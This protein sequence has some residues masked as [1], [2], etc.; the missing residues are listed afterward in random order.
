MSRIL[1]RRPPRRPGPEMPNGELTLQEPP[2]LPEKQATTSTVF[3]YLPMALASTATILIFV[4]PNAGTATGGSSIPGT[5]LA[6]GLMMVSS[7]A[8]L[9]G[10]LVRASGDRKRRVHGARRDYLRYLSQTRRRIREVVVDQR[11]AQSWRNP[12][13]DVLWSLA[14][15]SRLWER[16]TTHDDFGEVRIGVGEQRL[17]LRLAPLQT[18]PVEDLEPLCSHAL[19]RFIRAYGTVADQPVAV[20]L[21]GYSLVGLR[22]DVEAARAMVRAILGQLAVFHSPEE[23]RIGLC[24]SD[25]NRAK[26]EWLKWL[27]HALHRTEQDGAG[28]VRLIARG[29]V[30]LEELLGEEFGQRPR[31]DPQAEPTHEEPYTVIVLDGGD[32]PPGARAAG[33]GHRN[34]V[35]IDIEGTSG[36]E[37]APY[38]LGLDVAPR[39]LEMIGEDRNGRETTRPL[40][41]PDRLSLVR[42]SALARLLAPYRMS[43]IAEVTEPLNADFELTTLLSIDDMREHDVR[44][45]WRR[46]DPGAALRVPI[47]MSA[48]G[49]PVELDIKE[50]ALGGMGPH[51]ML[52]GATGSGKSELL[53]TLVLALALTHSSE[54]LNFVLVDFKGGATFLGLDELP[55]TSAVITNL[56][57]EV[58]LVARMQDALHGELIRRQELLRA[59]GNFSSIHEYENARAKGTPLAPLPALF[60]VV[61]EFS[62]LLAAHRE[63]MDL[64]VMIGR[65]GRS[66]G[67][68]LLLASQRLDE[69]RIHQL[70]SHLS[71]RIALRTF[72]A[73][74]SR[75]VL[76]S[77]DAYQLPPQP[78]SGFLK[79]DIDSLLRFKAAY[80]SGPYRPKRGAAVRTAATKLVPYTSR[81]VAPQRPVEPEPQPEET[82]EEADSLL[83][84]AIG[85]LRGVGPPAHQVWLPPLGVPPTLDELLGLEAGMPVFWR[86]PTPLSVPVG[87]VDRPFDQ[88]RDPLMADLSG[89]GGHVGIAGGPQSG[90]STL[91]RTLVTALTVT[92]SPRD[93]QFYCLDFGGGTLTALSGLPHVGGV[94][95]RLDIDRVNRTV[96]DIFTLLAHRERLFA[97]RG[98]DS[99]A[100]FRRMLAAGGLPGEQHGDVFLVVDGWSTLRQDFMDL[101]QNVAQ[102]GARGLNYGIHLMVASPRWS[103]IQPALR[104]QIATRFEL[105]LGD[106]VDSMVNMRVA[107]TVPRIPGRGLREDRLHFLTGLPRVDGRGSTADLSDGTAELVARVAGAWDGPRAP[108]V[109]MLPAILPAADLPEPDGD[110]RVPFGIEENELGPVR[111]DFETTP[112]LLV[113]GDTES[114]KTNLLRLFT[115]AIVER[116]TPDEAR[117]MLIDFR[118]ELYHAVP[119]EQQL[120][121]AVSIDVARQVIVAAAQSL[122]A[123]VPGP[124]ITPD[125]LR[126]RDWWEGPKLFVVCDDYDM[127]SGGG[128]AAGAFDPLLEVLAQGAE[129]GLHLLI[130][131]S[132][133]GVS[134]SMSDPLIRRLTELNTPALLMSCPQSEGVL[135]GGLRPRTLPPGRAQWFVRRRTIQVQ[136][137]LLPAPDQEEA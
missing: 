127:L 95:G 68:H 41:R 75:S 27:P 122:R 131:R 100:T 66:L 104:D 29:T 74:E 33:G 9:V 81:Y 4:R 37:L 34:A 119:A 71:Y 59:A 64:F 137:G 77:P 80:V 102:L 55:H 88:R 57:E 78:G 2:T 84:V 36:W 79:N 51:G 93:V 97:E 128:S 124:E 109:R 85:R 72:S 105:R 99:M 107:Q 134:R 108:A 106:A 121:Y 14:G 10:Q 112:H 120:G 94:T 69:G 32:V 48:D 136:T 98:I 19:R 23:L 3:T 123:R 50:S 16:K 25:E 53:R 52:I 116:Y 111:H 17:G 56:A 110:L 129:I 87:I 118:R 92:H 20:Y 40:G 44:A 135:F 103:E 73:M 58:A 83:S 90:K 11:D 117:V 62:E 7:M 26:W 42:A 114:G 82:E 115:Q 96:G 113:V 132:A 15:T 12:G 70:E 5:Y 22:G 76:G 65:L 67:V 60:V 30:E 126:R 6:A 38:V 133:G 13:P 1:F 39:T 91:L 43:M 89:A 35:V 61:D 24:V 21:K 54:V 125:R 47:G 28:Q 8:M 18:K 101:S 31:F 45:L 86:W 46:R 63:F 49:S 130:A